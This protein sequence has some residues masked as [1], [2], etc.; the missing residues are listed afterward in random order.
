V[1]K[2]LGAMAM[3]IFMVGCASSPGISQSPE[4]VPECNQVGCVEAGPGANAPNNAELTFSMCIGEGR[5]TYRYTRQSSGW[6][7]V[8]RDSVADKSCVAESRPN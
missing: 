7:L 6:L 8:S 1:T 4:W 3:L 5:S 2:F